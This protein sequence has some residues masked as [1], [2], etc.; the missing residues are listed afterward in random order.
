MFKKLKRNRL[1]KNPHGFYARKQMDKVAKKAG[2]VYAVRNGGAYYVEDMKQG[3]IKGDALRVI[4]Y[5]HCSCSAVGQFNDTCCVALYADGE[6]KVDIHM[7]GDCPH[8]NYIWAATSGAAI[9]A[10]SDRVGP[11]GYGTHL[12]I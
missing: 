11:R 8:C 1:R 4:H 3:N 10:R 2:F 5:L 7:V 12:R 9:K 6:I